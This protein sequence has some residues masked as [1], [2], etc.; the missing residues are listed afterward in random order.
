MLTGQKGTFLSIQLILVMLAEI[1][2]NK[3][4]MQGER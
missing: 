2:I 4:C 1:L 3:S